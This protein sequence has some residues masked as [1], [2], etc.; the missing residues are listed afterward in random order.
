MK[1]K[2]GMGMHGE[3][4]AFTDLLYPI[5]VAN[6]KGNSLAI[7]KTCSGWCKYQQMSQFSPDIKKNSNNNNTFKLRLIHRDT[8]LKEILRKKIHTPHPTWFVSLQAT[9]SSCEK[10]GEWQ[11]S[12]GHQWLVVANVFSHQKSEWRI[13]WCSYSR[14]PMWLM[15]P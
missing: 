15:S 6:S 4:H 3:G 2:R 9:I 11:R 13:A 8:G 12:S 10:S 14:T 1:Y 7:S 5:L